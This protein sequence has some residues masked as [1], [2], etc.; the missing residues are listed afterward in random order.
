MKALP[1]N[2]R[3]ERKFQRVRNTVAYHNK[4]WNFNKWSK[5]HPPLYWQALPANIRLEKNVNCNKHSSLFRKKP[6]KFNFW[7]S[8][9]MTSFTSKYQFGAQISTCGKHYRLLH[10]KI[11]KW[12][13]FP[14]SIILTVLSFA[15]MCLFH[16]HFM[17]KT[18][19][20]RKLAGAFWKH[21]WELACNGW[22]R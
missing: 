8:D 19:G 13:I 2:M 22:Y 11:N 21:S 15:K 5:F 18:Y 4:P 20:R 9:V 14:C 16:K 12:S 17:H 7:T 3:L 10:L 6:R 1:T